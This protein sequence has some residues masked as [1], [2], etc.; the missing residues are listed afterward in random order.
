MRCN[1][2]DRF[3]LRVQVVKRSVLFNSETERGLIIF[4]G[5]SVSSNMLARNRMLSNGEYRG[6]HCVGRYVIV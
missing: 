5:I 1:D 3:R 2:C 4:D 6:S